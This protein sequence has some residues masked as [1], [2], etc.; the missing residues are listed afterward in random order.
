[1][2]K[3]IFLFLL[4]FGLG[5]LTAQT[6]QKKQ[7]SLLPNS[8]KSSLDTIKILAV[9]VEFQEDKYDGTIGTGKFGSHYTQEYGDTILDPLPH[10]AEH[11][12]DHLEFAK[13]YYRKVSKGKV[14]LEYNVLPEV[15][16]VSKTMRF[17]SPQYNS[18][19]LT[20]LAEFSKEVW[21]LAAE[22]YPN[23][24]FG[25]YDL[26]II[27]HAGVSSGMDI[28]VFTIDR[29]LPS[30]YLSNHSLKNIF[31]DQFNGFQSG[32]GIITNTLIMPETNSREQIQIDD[33]V[34]L[35]QVSINGLLVNNIGNHLGLPDL[36]NTET[37]ISSIGKFGL[38]DAQSI[39]ANFG[40]FPPEPSPWEKIYLGWEEPVLFTPRDQIVN[41][42]ARAS[43]SISDTVVLQIPINST[44]YYLIENRLQDANKNNVI[45]TYKRSGII[46]QTVVEP[47]TNGYFIVDYNSIPG[48]VVIDVDEYDA[49][50]PGNGIVI[51]HIDEQIIQQKLPE[52]KINVNDKRKGVAV[53]EADGINDIGYIYDSIFGT[54]IGDGTIEDF[55]YKTNPS[56]LYKNR[57]SYDTKPNTNSNSGAK[58]LITMEDFSDIGNK[59]SFRISYGKN[60]IKNIVNKKLNI[61]DAKSINV[62]SIDNNTFYIMDGSDLVFVNGSGNEV[63]LDNFSQYV[64]AVYL[65][66]N[67]EY[68]FG[69]Y[70]D[71]LNI[72]IITLA[73]VPKRTHKL[74][75]SITSPVIVYKIDSETYIMAGMQDGY[76]LQVPLSILLSMSSIPEQYFTK[77]SDNEIIQLCRAFNSSNYFSLITSDSFADSEGNRITLP[78]KPIKAALTSDDNSTIVLSEQN[79]FYVIRNGQI[80]NEFVIK[81]LKQIN[82]FSVLADHKKGEKLILITNDNGVEAYNLMGVL[83]D[84]YPVLDMNKNNFSSLPLS[85]DLNSDSVNDIIAITENGILYVFDGLSG[86]VIEP[87]PLTIGASV[88]VSPFIYSYGND[89]AVALIDET[90]QL[91]SWVIG[92]S[93][94][95]PYWGSEYAGN[96]NNSTISIISQDGRITEFF[97]LDKTYNWPNPVYGSETNI[98]YYVAENAEIDIK[99]FDLA[100]GLVAELKDNAIGGY[101][102]ETIWNVTNIQS[103]VY[104]AR[105]EV[106]SSNGQSASKIIKIAIIK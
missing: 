11:F 97:P 73:K 5:S 37:G 18:Q 42:S 21:E 22:N 77:I 102:N 61:S 67:E 29:N 81:S 38:M 96:T 95:F 88:S 13:N 104:Y 71:L 46:Y 4:L 82:N 80:I 25:D 86:K 20:P 32:N 90:N 24:N 106:K 92:E 51:W 74:P 16:T 26:F 56:E 47:D 91:Y 62:S 101:D 57:F 78:Y 93:S 28:G 54:V 50:V 17:Y 52:N 66:N 43:A 33:S 58:S 34:F 70:D 84:N 2:K 7:Y 65:E 19:D 69:S 9:L 64:P 40:M 55:W 6:F 105:V 1:M 89:Y 103:G 85:I 39:A 76:L 30:V 36:F 48:G 83:S 59:M 15:L 8:V 23:F 14:N 63:R 87:F 49:A 75:H 60:K 31:G 68:I 98:R 35:F 44:E 41:I 12:K 72:S 99:I 94:D 100:G 79:R 45:I 3:N 53:V 10:D 27:F